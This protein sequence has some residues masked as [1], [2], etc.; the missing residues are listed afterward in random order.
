MANLKTFSFNQGSTTI[1][2]TVLSVGALKD[3]YYIPEFGKY[4]YGYQRTEQPRHVKQIRD[5]LLSQSEIPTLPTSVLL[6]VF[7]KDIEPYMR[8]HGDGTVSVDLDRIAYRHPDPV[9]RIIDGQHR[10]RGLEAAQKVRPE[11]ADYPLAVNIMVVEDSHTGKAS[12]IEAFVNINSK[13]KRIR[14]DLALLARYQ[15]KLEGRSGQDEFVEFI[16][17]SVAFLLNSRPQS[18]W[19]DAIV[20]DPNDPNGLI[21]VS[22]WNS[23]IR[24]LVKQCLT[25]GFGQR[26][27]YSSAE[28]STVSKA[29]TV[30]IDKAWKAVEKKWPGCF[31]PRD[32]QDEDQPRYKD[33]FVIQKP[34]GVHAIHMALEQV[35][36]SNIDDLEDN[37]LTP[38]DEVVLP[39]FRVKLKF[40]STT[41][42][43]WRVGKSFS[44]LTSQK[45][46]AI[47]RDKVFGK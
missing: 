37:D 3:L 39:D 6:G 36:A 29:V 8:D 18:V 26:N 22:A 28:C 21:S 30:V 13:A 43:D 33:T 15:L 20:V 31:I 19:Y 5:Y 35:M 10:V 24:R 16:C 46:F 25:F 34:I 11:F 9:F 47:V 27:Q 1:L 7:R 41:E 38:L 42:E 12:E 44:G 23:S 2:T 4:S 17:T 45:G 32:D 40:S 14:T